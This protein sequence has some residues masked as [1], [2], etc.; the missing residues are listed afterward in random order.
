MT[1]RLKKHFWKIKRYGEWGSSA[2]NSSA[3]KKVEC[4]VF[5]IFEK[6]IFL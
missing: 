4:L 5:F 3:Q 1:G 2:Q 6:K